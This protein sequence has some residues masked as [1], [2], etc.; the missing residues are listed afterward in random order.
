MNELD[1]QKRTRL[2]FL[3][4]RRKHKPKETFGSINNRFGIPSRNLSET[5]RNWCDFYRNLYRD[6]DE[7]IDFPTPDENPN[8]DRDFS[9]SEYLD[10][11]Y[12]LKRNKA[13]GFDNLV[14]EDIISL[15]E[16]ES[17][18]DPID[19]SLKIES[20]RFIFK[21]LT[22]FWFNESVPR[23]LKRTIL[24]PFLK[25]REK[26]NSEPSNY[27]PIS[28]LNTLMKIYE[29][30]I[31]CRL[32]FFYKKMIFS[33]RFKLHTAKIGPQQIIFW[34]CTNYFLNTGI[35]KRGLVGAK[36]RNYS[37]SAFLI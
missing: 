32:I 35:T 33:H 26:S 7:K 5:L 25:D 3:N 11:I 20:L 34:F 12:L 28:L 15:V 23:D 13:P 2:F 37:F 31:C 1:F 17:D 18:E 21:I 29:G 10:Q 16:E 19:P 36:L 8:L 30:M 24:R 4:L 9:L 27:R 14:N 22:D 6:T